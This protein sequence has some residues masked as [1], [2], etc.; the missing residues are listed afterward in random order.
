MDE[1]IIAMLMLGIIIDHEF[2]PVLLAVKR[3]S[4]LLNFPWQQRGQR[5]SA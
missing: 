2:G 3:N 5:C 1:L 4:A